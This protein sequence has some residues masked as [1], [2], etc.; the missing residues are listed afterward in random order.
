MASDVQRLAEMICGKLDALTREVCRTA[1]RALSPEKK[2]NLQEAISNTI[3]H[4]QSDVMVF[5][6]ILCNMDPLSA[7]ILCFDYEWDS[8]WKNLEANNLIEQPIEGQLQIQ[9]RTLERKTQTAAYLA[10]R[11][12][13]AIFVDITSIALTA[14]T[15][16][17]MHA[18]TSQTSSDNSRHT[19][20][21]AFGL[22]R[23][24]LNEYVQLYGSSITQDFRLEQAIR[25]ETIELDVPD[26]LNAQKFHLH[27]VSRVDRLSIEWNRIP[28]DQSR[29]LLTVFLPFWQAISNS[30]R[31]TLKDRPGVEVSADKE[32]HYVRVARGGVSGRF[33]PED[34][35]SYGAVC[36]LF[37][38]IKPPGE[39]LNENSQ[40]G[41][42]IGHILG[43]LALTTS[44][45]TARLAHERQLAQLEESHRHLTDAVERLEDI[46]KTSVDLA[47]S[48]QNAVPL[49]T[50]LI[51][52][53]SPASVLDLPTLS[54]L[55]G[56]GTIYDSGE[57]SGQRLRIYAKH[58]PTA[59]DGWR[60]VA[61]LR[62]L[63]R[64]NPIGI[65]SDE[66]LFS[67]ARADLNAA[68]R[69]VQK[70]WL[71]LLHGLTESKDTRLHE[72]LKAIVHEPKKRGRECS[73]LALVVRLHLARQDLGVVVSDTAISPEMLIANPL[74]YIDSKFTLPAVSGA[75]AEW[76]RLICDLL[77]GPLSE[78]QPKSCWCDRVDVSYKQSVGGKNILVACNITHRTARPGSFEEIKKQYETVCALDKDTLAS[79]LADRPTENLWAPF[80]KLEQIRRNQLAERFSWKVD[81]LQITVMLES[82]R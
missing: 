22:Y 11:L 43:S 74:S 73:L 1:Y 60:A 72:V 16:V 18:Y 58:D 81:R 45:E 14:G 79:A 29:Y 20:A 38:I 47:D 67:S 30:N 15:P 69:F 48:I 6:N 66:Q 76:M 77:S 41:S 37:M 50:Q 24:H 19:V 12:A 23:Q 75:H 21:G 42:A 39:P 53:S 26:T 49:A 56:R 35:D 10:A 78:E 34:T 59:D 8:L 70:W 4:S 9:S 55:F 31:L 63:G 3:K 5:E 71:K 7:S 27:I 25:S 17:C 46:R 57:V 61:L 54:D 32:Y 82:N 36:H 64:P 2:L 65:T 28:S 33:N 62:A 44:S 51:Q 80:L 68:N 13:S 52:A 40:V